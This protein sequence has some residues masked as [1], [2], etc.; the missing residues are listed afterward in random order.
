MNFVLDLILV[1]ICFFT[2]FF[3]AKRGFIRSIMGFASKIIALIVAYT[4]TPALSEF[5]KT[6]FLIGPLSDSI[7]SYLRT[8]V[9]RDGVYDFTALADK[10]PDLLQRYVISGDE[11][12]AKIGSME[13]TGEEALRS[14][15]EHIAGKGSGMIA[16][17]IAFIGLFIVTCFV[18]WIVT[19]VA[20]AV[21]KL[22]VLNAA[23]KVLGVAFGV[24]SAV[25]LTLVYSA[26]VSMLV[27]ALGAVAP[28]VFGEDV[29][30]KTILVKFFANKDLLE[31]SKNLIS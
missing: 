27:G 20:D 13:Q 24:L 2:V 10:V 1:A 4:F 28:K 6:R 21:F 18:L 7:G 23:N 14:V 17:A 31:I 9:V 3:A 26:E 22:P 12:S 11:L 16:T 5:I 30:D 19:R 15:S 8:F 29:L 25:L